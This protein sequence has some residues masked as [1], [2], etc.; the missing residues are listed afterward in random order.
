[1]KN[2]ERLVVTDLVREQPNIQS[3]VKRQRKR[4][5]AQ[6]SNYRNFHNDWTA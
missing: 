2:F 3:S 4:K 1:M 6:Y 5:D